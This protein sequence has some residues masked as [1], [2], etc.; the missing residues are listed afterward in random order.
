MED[1]A[2]SIPSPSRK[3][4]GPLIQSRSAIIALGL[5]TI[6][7]FASSMAALALFLYDSGQG[8]ATLYE[9]PLSLARDIAVDLF[10]LISYGALH[11]A[12]LLPEGRQILG[13]LA[14]RGLQG[15]LYGLFASITLL[16]TIWCW[17]PLP[18]AIYILEGTPRLAMSLAYVSAW[19]FMAWAMHATGPLAQPGIEQWWNTL[20]GKPTL[21]SDPRGGPYRLVRHPIYLGMIGMICLTPNMTPGHLLISLTWTIYML[22][23]ATWKE[24]R[25]LDRAG[26]Y[27]KYCSQVPPFPFFPRR[28]LASL[29]RSLGLAG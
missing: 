19:A 28:P 14:Q 6:L 7:T 11:S 29:W 3:R 4:S 9:N 1:P 20:R 5:I 8:G 17:R 25:M 24:G 13:R 2:R 15:T 12:L 23:G 27:E 18:G 10:L 26:D 21:Y 22:L 16:I